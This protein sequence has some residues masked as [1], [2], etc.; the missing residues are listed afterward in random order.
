MIYPVNRA[1]Y[2]ADVSPEE[3]R[4]GLELL[5]RQGE[6]IPAVKSF[7]VGADL[8]GDYEAGAIFLIEDLDGFWEYL[9]HPAHSNQNCGAC[10]ASNGSKHSTPPTPT[11]LTTATR[12]PSCKHVALSRILN[13]QHWWPTLRRSPLPVTRSLGSFWS[14]T[15][16]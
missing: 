7:V 8:G 12:S 13:S 9:T 3:K 14:S 5:R 4:H 11:T 10:R 6:A 1:S 15:G 16:R 2:K